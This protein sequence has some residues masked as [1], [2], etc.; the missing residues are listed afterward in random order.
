MY[1]NACN[2]EMLEICMKY[3]VLVNV[4]FFLY[5]EIKDF[6]FHHRAKRAD[7]FQKDRKSER[8]ERKHLQTGS[9]YF[10]SKYNTIHFD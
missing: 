5:M 2:L 1:F 4:V 7:V 6:F 8:R 9:L 10:S 3:S